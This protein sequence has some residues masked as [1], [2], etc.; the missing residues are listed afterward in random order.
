MIQLRRFGF[1]THAAGAHTATAAGTV[2]ES[3]VARNTCDACTHLIHIREGER[4][5]FANVQ[6]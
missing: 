3:T 2:A 6:K 5:S 1:V 4:Y